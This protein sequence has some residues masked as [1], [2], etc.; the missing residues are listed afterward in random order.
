[1]IAQDLLSDNITP[2]KTSDTGADAIKIMEEYKV[3]HLPIVNN[4]QFLGLISET[5]IIEHNKLD[6]AIGNHN[7]SLSGASVHK[8]Q[9]IYEVLKIAGGLKLTLIPVVDDDNTYLGTID[10]ITLIKSFSEVL[11]VNNPGGIIILELNSNDFSLTEI[12]SIIESNDA[13]ILSL[14]I[15]SYPDSTKI[16]VTIKLNR[17]DIGPVLQTFNRYQYVIK[18]SYY[19]SNYFDDLKDRFDAFLHY[20]NI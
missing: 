6:D 11:A 16:E 17:M 1:M 14:Y 3:T 9:H 5:D 13:K 19:E 20:L 4:E 8:Y 7:L 2:L 15:S 10:L 12:A 18:A